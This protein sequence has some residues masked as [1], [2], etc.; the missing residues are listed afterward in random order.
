MR[1]WTQLDPGKIEKVETMLKRKKM[2]SWTQLDPGK[3][4][5]VETM[6]KRKL[7]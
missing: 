5:K 7:G 3:I 2:R 6:I 4:E 1:A